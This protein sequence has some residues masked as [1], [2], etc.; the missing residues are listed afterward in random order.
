[1]AN[2]LSPTTVRIADEPVVNMKLTRSHMEN[3]E[4][5]LIGCWLITRPTH[6]SLQCDDIL[7]YAQLWL[8]MYSLSRYLNHVLTMKDKGLF[9][10]RRGI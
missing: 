7:S 4:E 5:E 10:Y 1:M 3:T 2:K 8:Q 6:F 9:V